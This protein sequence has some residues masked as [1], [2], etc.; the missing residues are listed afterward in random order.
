MAEADAELEQ[1]IEQYHFVSREGKDLEALKEQY[2]AQI[3]DRIGEASKV[4]SSL[5]TIS[6][7]MTKP[8]EG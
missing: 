8:S 4:I 7:G 1:L 2:K 5:G 6:C 3:L